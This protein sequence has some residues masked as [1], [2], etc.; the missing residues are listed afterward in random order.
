MDGSN[1]TITGPTDGSGEARILGG[2][3][4]THRALSQSTDSEVWS[5]IPAAARASVRVADLTALSGALGK[6]AALSSVEGEVEAFLDGGT[7]A[8]LPMEPFLDGRPLIPAQWPSRIDPDL[9]WATNTTD[10]TWTRVHNT[11]ELINTGGFY[12]KWRFPHDPTAP[13]PSWTDWD[14]VVAQVR[15]LRHC[16]ESCRVLP[17]SPP[18]NVI[19]VLTVHCGPV[20]AGVPTRCDRFTS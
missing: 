10:F 13:F 14:D 20:D 2:K 12:K 3:V 17:T 4:A 7:A 18:W 9:A 15:Q 16:F 19:C 8:D 5:K 6:T 1:V 11:G